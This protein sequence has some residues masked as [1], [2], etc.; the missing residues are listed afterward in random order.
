M[1]SLFEHG[2][3]LTADGECTLSSFVYNT[4]LSLPG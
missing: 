1:V 2:L 3:W 4:L